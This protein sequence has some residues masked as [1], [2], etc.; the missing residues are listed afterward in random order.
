MCILRRF[1]LDLG[2]VFAPLGAHFGVP[3]EGFLETLLRFW[4]CAG[5]RSLFGQTL[6]YEV[7]EVSGSTCSSTFQVLIPYSVF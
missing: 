2:R 1:I 4:D 7:W 6:L 5:L 3:L